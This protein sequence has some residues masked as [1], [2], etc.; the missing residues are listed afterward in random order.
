MWRN[1][2]LLY[3]DAFTHR[4]FYTQTLLL[5]AAFTHRHFYTQTRL[6]AQKL[7]HTDAFTHGHFYIQELLHTDTFTHR[8][9]YTQTLLHTDTF[10]RRS[11][12]TK[13]LFHT[14]A[15]THRLLYTQTLL[16][17]KPVTHRHFYRPTLSLHYSY[18][19]TYDYNYNYNCATPHYIQ[20]LWWGDH[21]NHCNHCKRKKLQ[22]PVG[23]P[24]D[25]L[26]HPWITTTNLSYRFPIFE[27]S[28]TALCGT[29][30]IIWYNKVSL[31]CAYQEIGLH[32]RSRGT[33][34]KK[35]DVTIFPIFFV[36]EKPKVITRNL[37]NPLL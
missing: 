9:F 14:G 32:G 18:N 33:C 30:G 25:S 12:Y 17:T 26:C 35:L 19:Y 4:S 11:F 22:P 34:R 23:P 29:T 5:T 7:L 16:Q 15:F 24:V 8:R 13:T 1:A 2:T 37:I 21:C 3:R 10:T 6:H 31:Y 20:Q 27:T 28:A 36:W